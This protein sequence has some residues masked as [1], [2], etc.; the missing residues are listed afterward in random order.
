MRKSQPYGFRKTHRLTK[1]SDFQRVYQG[2]KLIKN[3]HFRLYVLP[4]EGE[5]T[6][7]LGLSVSKKMGKAVVRNR[8]KRWIREWFRTR[9]D[10]L[11]GLD[12]VVQPKPPAVALD[13]EALEESLEGLVVSLK[14]PD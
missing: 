13:H 7:R 10:E 4:R 12:I 14:A 3:E 2:G 9:K 5:S 8:L 1:G 6:P 11:T